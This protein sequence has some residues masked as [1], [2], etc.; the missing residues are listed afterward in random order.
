MR[1]IPMLLALASLATAADPAPTPAPK[2][3]RVYELRTYFAAPDKLPALQTRFRDHTTKLF[4]KHGI[5]NVGYWTPIE[6]TE[7]KLVYIVSFT[8]LDA[9]K[10]AWKDFGADAEWKKVHAESEK[11]GKLVTKI[12]SKIMSATDFSPEIKAAISNPTR[13]FEM[14]TYTTTP[15]N[16]PKLHARFRDHTIGLFSKHGMKHFGYWKVDAGQPDAENTLI[17]L[18]SHNS[19][20]ACATSFKE[21]RAD[22]VWI[23]AKAASEKEAGGSLTIENGV[24]SELLVPTDFSPTR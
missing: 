18:L 11:D 23:A 4:E 24:K 16:L 13:V 6:N 19:K 1:F 10:Q 22:P 14:R 8:S 17:Y 21:F 12:D 2:D 3:T 7:N 5:T 9:R 20:E 15:G